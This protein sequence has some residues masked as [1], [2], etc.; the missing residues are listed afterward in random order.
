MGAGAE[1]A[2]R[3]EVEVVKPAGMYS[4]TP[5]DRHLI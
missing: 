3:Q 1:P 2:G 5:N 4:R